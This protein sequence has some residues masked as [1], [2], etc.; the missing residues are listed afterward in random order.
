MMSNIAK[1]VHDT[2]MSFAKKMGR[3][4]SLVAAE[5]NPSEAHRPQARSPR[6]SA[7][8]AAESLLEALGFRLQRAARYTWH[9]PLEGES[10]HPTVW[11][12]STRPM[13]HPEVE[14]V[15]ERL[16]DLYV[17][18]YRA[19][20][21]QIKS[22][23]TFA[24][25]ELLVRIR[26]GRPELYELYRP[27]V[28]TGLPDAM[29]F[30]EI[31]DRR[32]LNFQPVT[33]EIGSLQVTLRP[34]FW[35]GIEFVMRGVPE[36]WAAFEK[37]IEEWIDPDDVKPAGEDGLAQ[38]IHNVVL[39]ETHEGWA[40]STC[41]DF[42]SAPTA[43]FWQLLAVLESMGTTQVEIG[44]SSLMDEELV[45]TREPSWPGLFTNLAARPA[46][47]CVAWQPTATRLRMDVA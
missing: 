20:L 35:N 31:N 21:A 26:N 10:L 18:G 23:A 24:Q 42:G 33:F 30:V 14:D 44:S 17:D 3:P 16:R 4:E 12:E 8:V 5:S 43:A 27:D 46:V 29:D 41:I 38:V 19:R 6:R 11:E 34:A 36:S 1:M 45:H 47:I 7:E 32:F 9:R 22:E 28:A 25:P 2:A 37:W 15:V 40:W 39:P 13:E